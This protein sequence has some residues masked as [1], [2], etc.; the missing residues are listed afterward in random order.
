MTKIGYNYNIFF[1]RDDVCNGSVGCVLAGEPADVVTGHVSPQYQYSFTQ[2]PQQPLTRRVHATTFTPEVAPSSAT[3][4]SPRCSVPS[5]VSAPVVSKTES[6][7]RVSTAD[8]SGLHCTRCSSAGVRPSSC[9]R[10]VGDLRGKTADGCD[11][12]EGGIG[13]AGTEGKRGASAEQV[14]DV[15][16]KPPSAGTGADRTG[17]ENG[18]ASTGAGREQAEEE[19]DEEDVARGRERVGSC[20]SATSEEA[21][22][23]G[24]GATRLMEQSSDKCELKCESAPAVESGAGVT[25]VPDAGDEPATLDRVRETIGGRGKR[26]ETENGDSDLEEAGQV[27]GAS[28]VVANM[29]LVVR[30]MKRSPS[31]AGGPHDDAASNSGEPSHVTIQLLGCLPV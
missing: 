26:E 13:D 28:E 2:H 5:T 14:T 22:G 4:K 20:T 30:K 17:G 21:N 25:S 23:T 19:E 7:R 10:C 12:L 27:K 15:D 6:E 16:V 24:G 18:A 8:N 31:G 29:E 11:L 3:S 9:P 1:I